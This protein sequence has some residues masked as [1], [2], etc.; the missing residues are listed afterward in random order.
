MYV[1]TDEPAEVQTFDRVRGNVVSQWILKIL[2]IDVLFA[3]AGKQAQEVLGSEPI[4]FD[5]LYFHLTSGCNFVRQ[6]VAAGPKVLPGEMTS[7]M[8]GGGFV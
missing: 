3:W 8:G 1:Q 7:G 5:W 4:V 6:I 2:R